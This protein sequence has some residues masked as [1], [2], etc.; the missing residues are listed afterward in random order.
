MELNGRYQEEMNRKPV[1]RLV[2]W[3][4][5]ATLGICASSHTAYTMNAIKAPYNNLAFLPVAMIDGM[6]YC[7]RELIWKLTSLSSIC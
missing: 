3:L 5:S 1:Y 7:Y 4:T 6:T 2:E